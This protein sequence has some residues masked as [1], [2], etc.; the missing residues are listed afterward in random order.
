[1]ISNAKINKI[2]NRF[3]RKER[4]IIYQYN[5][6]DYEYSRM[7]TNIHKPTLTKLASG[8]NH[9]LAYFYYHNPQKYQAV[10]F[11]LFKK[12]VDIKNDLKRIS[13]Q[14]NYIEIVNDYVC[15]YGVLDNELL[16]YIYEY[17][18]FIFV[19]NITEK[20]ETTVTLHGVHCKVLLIMATAVKFSF[21]YSTAFLGTNN[22]FDSAMHKFK[23]ILISRI[24][25][26]VSSHNLTDANGK[27]ISPEQ[28][29]HDIES[30]IND[31]IQD[32]WH[33]KT[34]SSFRRKF[35]EVG[36]DMLYYQQKNEIL[37][38]TSFKQ[39]IPQLPM[40]DYYIRK[41]S[42]DPN[43]KLKDIYYIINVTDFSDFKFYALALTAYIQSTIYQIITKQ[44][45][46]APRDVVNTPEFLSDLTDDQTLRRDVALYEDKEKFFFQLRSETCKTFFQEVHDELLRM[47]KMH[48]I[49]H[50]SY[51]S[52]FKLNQD[53]QLN[54]FILAKILLACTGEF[55]TYKRVFGLLSKYILLLFYL[56]II[57]PDPETG[58]D[59]EW[60]R[61]I[62]PAMLAE[63]TGISEETHESI[64][65]F[66]L[67]EADPKYHRLPTEAFLEMCRLYVGQNFQLRF[68][69]EVVLDLYDLLSDSFRLR[70]ILF[71][72]KYPKE[73]PETV[74]DNYYHDSTIVDKGVINQLASV[75]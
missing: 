38:Y 61:N 55:N 70:H 16:E 9:F 2:P 64:Q 23:S 45:T 62:I 27:Y 74:Y 63:P 41:Y 17:I 40:D 54:Q 25:Q 58:E 21:M 49:D 12:F 48:N 18:D 44:D 46:K 36:R 34:D 26:V 7:K 51:I 11:Y 8:L 39:Y 15:K 56:K 3:D 47:F 32:V 30:F 50:L 10:T 69:K 31:R 60:A 52:S 71:P 14:E 43:T 5:G 24:I 22:N 72:L 66:L 53:H 19:D 75:I 65:E 13:K 42:D 20:A 4:K 35:E 59:L 57:Y 1:M 6:T 73:Y 37:V 33:Q 67:K 29:R 68:T 28:I